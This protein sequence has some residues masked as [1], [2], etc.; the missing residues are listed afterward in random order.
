MA[1]FTR[2]VQTPDTFGM[3]PRVA[4]THR[5]RAT[6]QIAAEEGR[7]RGGPCPAVALAT[8]AGKTYHWAFAYLARETGYNG[9]GEFR[10]ALDRAAERLFGEPTRVTGPTPARVRDVAVRLRPT[11]NG[12]IYCP[13]HVMPVRNGRVLNASAKHLARRCDGMTL[14]DIAEV[15]E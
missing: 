14:F 3:L 8:I 10:P 1:K 2:T 9:S 11:D 4:R 13:G 12:F 7:H 15:R 6:G 5:A